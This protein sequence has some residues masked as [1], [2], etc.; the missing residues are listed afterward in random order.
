LQ[1]AVT[2]SADEA[3]AYGRQIALEENSQGKEDILA[4]GT[5]EIIELTPEQRQAFRDVV[6]PTVWDQYAE[7]I[8]GDV[9]EYVKDQQD[10]GGNVI[11]YTTAG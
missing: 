11:E 9:I 3:A 5:S 1:Q 2:E 6:A 10:P 8:G 4:A 7:E